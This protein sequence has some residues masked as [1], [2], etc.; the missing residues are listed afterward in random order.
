MQK[1]LGKA[2]K[3]YMVGE[4]QHVYAVDNFEAESG[5]YFEGS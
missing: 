4:D 2:S 1:G 3:L 5:A